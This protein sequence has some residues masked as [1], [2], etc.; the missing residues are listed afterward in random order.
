MIEPDALAREWLETDGLGGF[1]SGTVAGWRTRRYH[2]L[3]TPAVVPPTGRAVLADGFEAW[4]EQDGTR[5]PLST[6]RYAPDVTHPD[7]FSRLAAF[8][9]D[10]WPTWTFELPGGLTLTQELLVPHERP[11]V[12]LRW[13]LAPA[14]PGAR[15]IVRPLLSGRDSHALHREN[16]EL[17]LDAE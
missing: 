14:T 6:Q 15:L 7:G 11:A 8:T 10:P 12:M 4:L 1:A 17:R 9:I 13:S 16:G 3:L 5:T 2:G